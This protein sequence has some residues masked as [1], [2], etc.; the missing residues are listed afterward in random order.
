M[1]SIVV[2][3]ES[4]R[5]RDGVAGVRWQ[6]DRGLGSEVSHPC[7]GKSRKGAA[8]S[9]QLEL[10]N[11]AAQRIPGQLLVER[12]IAVAHQHDKRPDTERG[13]ENGVQQI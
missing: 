10:A 3:A 11:G 8:R 5:W 9:V 13:A 4:H 2:E 6:G 12:G 7:D 1:V